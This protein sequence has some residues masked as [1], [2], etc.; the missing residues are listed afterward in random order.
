MASVEIVSEK[1]TAEKAGLTVRGISSSAG[2]SKTGKPEKR[3]W[4]ENGI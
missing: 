2:V 1:Y 3:I 4:G